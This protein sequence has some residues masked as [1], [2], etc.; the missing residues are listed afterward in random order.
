MSESG[1]IKV[2]PVGSLATGA[3]IGIEAGD[4]QIAIYSVAGEFFA[5]DNVCTHAFALLTDGYLDGDVVECP[6]HAGCFNVKTGQG[7]GEPITED[8]KTH[9]V[10][11][12]DGVI[13]VRVP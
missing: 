5:T 2:A 13:E 11:I 6:L 10:R 1:W 9:P 8:I 12:T 3:M 4:L 7:L